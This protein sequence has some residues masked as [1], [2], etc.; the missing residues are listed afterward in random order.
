[1]TTQTLPRTE[2]DTQTGAPK[3]RLFTRKE[4]HAMG[5]AG[6]LGHGERVELLEGEIVAMS[7][8]GSRHAFCVD[9]LNYEFAALNIA[10]R[11][12][13]RVQ[14]PAAT[15]STSEPEPDIMLIAHREDR[16]LSGHPRPE[17]IMLLIEVADSSLYHDVNVKL[18]HYAA[19]GIPETWIV[20]L[21]DDQVEAHTE[22]SSAGYRA[23]RIYRIGD[24][25]SPTAF[26]DIEISIND[27]IPPRTDTDTS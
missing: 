19:V 20:N 3:K 25:I 27:I 21:Q 2:T 23:S 6:I 18:P 26:P 11:A 13:A 16:Y 15:S 14:G 17:D 12:I 7:P 5:E 1:M 8:I 9:Q 24:T 4:Y 22:P 10:R